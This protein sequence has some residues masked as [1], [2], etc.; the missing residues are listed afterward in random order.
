VLW[1]ALSVSG[2]SAGLAVPVSLQTMG[3]DEKK[4]V[5]LGSS[6]IQKA[7]L[8][9]QRWKEIKEARKRGGFGSIV[10]GG[11]SVTAAVDKG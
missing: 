9:M 1:A 10:R 8:K 2:L 6:V 4:V 3:N 5:K 11:K 7:S